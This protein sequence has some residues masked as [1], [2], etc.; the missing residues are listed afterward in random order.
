MTRHRRHSRADCQSFV[1]GKVRLAAKLCRTKRASS[2][3]V[4][5]DTWPFGPSDLLGS[6]KPCSAW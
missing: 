4:G 1:N 6:Q 5:N 2:Q 3:D